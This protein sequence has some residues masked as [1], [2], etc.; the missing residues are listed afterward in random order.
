MAL[1]AGD[2]QTG[3]LTVK[4]VSMQSARTQHAANTHPARTQHA[5]ST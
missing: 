2:A 4:Y 5:A 3:K 1:K